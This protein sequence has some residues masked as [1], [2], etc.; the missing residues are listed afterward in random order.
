MRAFS[1][2][3][4]TCFRGPTLRRRIDGNASAPG[5][6]PMHARHLAVL[7]VL[8]LTPPLFADKIDFARLISSRRQT[9]ESADIG[10]PREP[11]RIV[12]GRDE[13]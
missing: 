10:G 7:L 13:R 2:T 4:A 6:P 5:V 9:K 1:R 11:V 12:Y 8:L 3:I